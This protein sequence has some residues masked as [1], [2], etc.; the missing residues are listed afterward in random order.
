[1]CSSP[2]RPK[3][4]GRPSGTGRSLSWRGWGRG[5]GRGSYGVRG[6]HDFVAILEAPDEEMGVR[7]PVEM[8]A[9]GTVQGMSLPVIPVR[10]LVQMLRR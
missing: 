9:R 3:R 1:M 8:G 7:I 6:P 2:R 4:A 5:W 10:E